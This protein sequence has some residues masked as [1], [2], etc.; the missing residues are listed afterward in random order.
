MFRKQADF[1]EDISVEAWS[2]HLHVMQV[3]PSW[4]VEIQSCLQIIPAYVLGKQADFNEDISVEAWNLHL[5][6]RCKALQMKSH[7]AW[8][9]MPWETFDLNR[10]TRISCKAFRLK[11][12]ACSFVQCK[13]FPVTKTLYD[14]WSAGSNL[15]LS[16]SLVIMEK[17]PSWCAS[18]QTISLSVVPML[19]VQLRESLSLIS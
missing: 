8:T 2:M 18:S 7:E 4:S 17:R 19:A 1:N 14:T 15:A 12:S 13:A 5:H 16:F 10:E 11:R 9:F 3:I 6:I